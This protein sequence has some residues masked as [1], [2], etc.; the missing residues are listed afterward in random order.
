MA[1]VLTLE[2][3]LRANIKGTA[4]PPLLQGRQFRA[5]NAVELQSPSCKVEKTHR[6]PIA[7]EARGSA[8]G[9]S[10][11][12]PL[13]LLVGSG[14]PVE[15][16]VF[17]RITTSSLLIGAVGRLVA[18]LV[19]TFVIFVRKRSIPQGGVV[20]CCSSVGSCGVV[21]SC[22]NSEKKLHDTLPLNIGR[23]WGLSSQFW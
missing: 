2:S 13:P 9:V 14:F 20:T 11:P 12:L 5:R 7:P 23:G 10:F 18:G 15:P 6:I 17:R 3:P 19:S 21:P 16:S 4:A 1:K 8:L 22:F